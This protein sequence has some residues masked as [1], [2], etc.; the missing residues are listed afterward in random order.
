ME[1][2]VTFLGKIRKHLSPHLDI[3]AYCLMPNHFHLLVHSKE[4]ID[5]PRY[6]QDLR[7]MLSSYTRKIN[8]RTKRTG[9]LFQQNTKAKPLEAKDYA[10]TCF[11]Y[12]HQNPLRAQLVTKMEDWEFGSYR[13]YAGFRNGTLCIEGLA[14]LLLDIPENREAFTEQSKM[15]IDPSKANKFL[16]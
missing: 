10:F 16:L 11:H 5:I 9:S 3:L 13:D 8:F 4:A 14:Y 2:Y 12:I 1:D 15:V 6:R 7:M